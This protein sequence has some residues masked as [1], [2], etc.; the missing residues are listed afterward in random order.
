MNCVTDYIDKF[1]LKVEKQ[2]PYT[3]ENYY[4]PRVTEILS[5]M[6]CDESLVSWSNYIGRYQHKNYSVVLNTAA[7]IGTR[8]H[9]AIENY[10][11]HGIGIDD[12]SIPQY[13]ASEVR[14]AFNSFIIWWD[15]ISKHDISILK[16]EYPLV[17]K[18]FGG[19]LDLLLKIDGKIYLVDFKTSNHLS[20]RYH[21][22]LAA[23]RYMLKLNE[24]IDLDGIII[25]QLSK[26]SIDFNEQM[27]LLDNQEMLDYINTCEQTFM[28]LV[29]SYYTK[30]NMVSLYNGYFK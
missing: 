29:Y 5:T 15:I 11:Q 21:L 18:Y 12:A 24:N 14:N 16:E 1:D 26:N 20:Y 8:V 27:I 13:I 28:S 6:L 2:T 22:Q 19:T 23:Y 10:I 4:V 17:C 30:Y 9:E 7:D 3:Y 25:L